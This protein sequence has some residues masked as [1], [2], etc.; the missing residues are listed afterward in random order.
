M[1]DTTKLEVRPEVAAFVAE[2]RARLA[3]LDSEVQE[4]LVG[5]L[6][7]DL[8]DLVADQ[9]LGALG[10]AQAY[11]DELRAAAGLPLRPSRKPRGRR[12]AVRRIGESW[13]TA[14]NRLLDSVRGRWLEWATT[15]WR[16]PVWDLLVVVRPA[17]W[18]LRA[19][20]AVQLMDILTGPWESP[21]LIPSL[22]VDGLGAVLV[23]ALAVPSVLVGLGRWWPGTAL[24]SSVAARIV[25]LAVNSAAVIGAV[26]WID[27][28]A[29]NVTVPRQF[30]QEGGHR[31][32]TVLRVGGERLCNIQAY[33]AQG[34]PLIGVQLYDQDG[35]PINLRCEAPYGGLQTY[36]WLLGS[37]RRWNVF[38]LP[39][40]RQAYP[41][42][43]ADAY[44]SERPPAFPQSDAATVPEVTNPLGPDAPPEPIGHR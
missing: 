4:E 29:S 42:M 2:V 11:A 18:L 23:L 28:P 26:G 38:P 32:A 33:G 39:E 15:A 17:W 31:P 7:A 41:G 35:R 24:T 21:T 14:A 40:R 44:D 37:E 10:D 36:P 6:D 3:D 16:G 5:G 30:V 22:G 13:P 27:F 19:W 34:N 9:G 25:V 1:N 43:R 20:V 8:V 12:L